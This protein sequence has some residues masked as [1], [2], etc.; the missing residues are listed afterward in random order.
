M[1]FSLELSIFENSTNFQIGW[2]IFEKFEK[3]MNVSFSWEWNFLDHG[4]VLELQ[5][6]IMIQ[7]IQLNNYTVL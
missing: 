4:Y 3:K 7:I 2:E 6:Q 5:F 1:S